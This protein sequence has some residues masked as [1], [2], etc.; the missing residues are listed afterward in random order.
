VAIF[1]RANA[2]DNFHRSLSTGGALER[3]L[4]IYGGTPGPLPGVLRSKFAYRVAEY[5]DPSSLFNAKR[6]PIAVSPRFFPR[7][8]LNHLFRHH[9]TIRLFRLL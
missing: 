1:Q 2:A 7:F 8:S 4:L 6:R 3:T 5:S 9:D